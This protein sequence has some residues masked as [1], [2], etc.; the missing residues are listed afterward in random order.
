MR[1]AALA[2]L[3]LVLTPP[4]LAQQPPSPPSVT[5][6]VVPDLK[7][8]VPPS[9]E[10]PLAEPETFENQKLWSCPR[11]DTDGRAGPCKL[12][13]PRKQKH[14]DYGKPRLYPALPV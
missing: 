13:E 3:A 8:V 6:R 2:L 12:I 1:I 7:S 10:G 9:I 4:A 5:E 11:P 14:P